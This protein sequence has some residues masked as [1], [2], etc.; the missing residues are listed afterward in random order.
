MRT[1]LFCT[2]WA[3]DQAHM[4]G[5]VGKWLKHHAGLPYPR[6]TKLAVIGDGI[7]TEIA[8]PHGDYHRVNLEPHLG[9]PSHLDYP[10]WWRSFAHSAHVA[11]ELGCER[12]W[13]CESDFMLCSWRMICRMNEIEEGWVAFWCGRHSMP[14]TGVQVISHHYFD[15]LAAFGQRINTLGGIHAEHVIP[16]TS[17]IRDMVGDRFG[18]AGTPP[19]AIPMVDYYGQRPGEMECFYRG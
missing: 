13:H 2:A 3:S 10:G 5:R 11:R 8:W 12:I 16:F 18:E 7:A 19:E 17:I 4:D 1:L 6:E 9:R 15:T 14:E